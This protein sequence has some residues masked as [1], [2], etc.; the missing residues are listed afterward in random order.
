MYAIKTHHT[1]S[2]NSHKTPLHAF[3]QLFQI[4]TPEKIRFSFENAYVQL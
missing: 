4:I 2:I 1:H 3:L